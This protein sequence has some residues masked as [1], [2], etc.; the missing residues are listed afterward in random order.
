MQESPVTKHEVPSKYSFLSPGRYALNRAAQREYVCDV[1]LGGQAVSE[2]R[3]S[4]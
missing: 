1:V 4:K 2:R 3:H